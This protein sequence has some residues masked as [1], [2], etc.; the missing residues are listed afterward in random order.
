MAVSSCRMRKEVICESGALARARVY[1]CRNWGKRRF[2]RSRE[3]G[4]AS[5]VWKRGRVRMRFGRCIARRNDVRNILMELCPTLQGPSPSWLVT[6]VVLARFRRHVHEMETQH[7]EMSSEQSM[8]RS[9]AI[10][11][12]IVPTLNIDINDHRQGEDNVVDAVPRM[13][14]FKACF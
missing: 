4:L 9:A 6:R 13:K 10:A 1:L 12:R 2:M 5:V 7:F 11:L 14:Q 8:R 3:E